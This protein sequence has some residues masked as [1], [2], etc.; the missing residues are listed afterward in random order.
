MTDR[1][2]LQ[3]RL[4]ATFKVEA[5]EH[6]EALSR[7]L[8]D[9]EQAEA[10]AATEL[11]ETVFREVHSLKGAA[12]S[13]G[14]LDI[15]SVCQAL[16]NIFSALKRGKLQRSASLLDRLL[17]AQR[18]LEQLLTALESGRL[19]SSAGV[20][21]LVAALAALLRVEGSGQLQPGKPDQLRTPNPRGSGPVEGAHQ[22]L[23]LRA[24][25]PG[26]AEGKVS[27][28]PASAFAELAA[29]VRDLTLGSAKAEANRE[30]AP[31]EIS[32]GM[33]RPDALPPG[34]AES[35]ASSADL[36]QVDQ[37]RSTP[38]APERPPA[39]WAAHANLSRSD[40]R[41][42]SPAAPVETVRVATER[43]DQVRL[44][45]EDLLMEKLSLSQHAADL[46]RLAER[47]RESR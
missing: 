22:P 35:L 6:L 21:A 26:A 39:P 14:A 10:S 19:N 7:G 20:D 41:A 13:V 36:H 9:L 18:F 15:E 34:A 44:L 40:A 32:A 4:L 2:A 28:S 23:E 46:T 16:E 3:R 5:R 27:G 31:P 38:E 29:A 30:P 47:L 12:R 17:E 25:A 33:S 8:M 45:A 1:E 37:A 11:V 43:L 42:P 24:A